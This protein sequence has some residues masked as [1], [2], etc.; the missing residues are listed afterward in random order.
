MAVAG[1]RERTSWKVAEEG[2]APAFVLEVVTEESRGRDFD[3]KPDIYEA[4]KVREYAA[5]APRR[6]D[7][8]PLLS[9]FQ[10]RDDGVFAPWPASADGALR[11]A[12]M[13]LDLVVVDERWL[14]LR[15]GNGVLAP[16]AEEEAAATERERARAESEASRADAAAREARAQAERADAAEVELSRLRALLENRGL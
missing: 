3:H 5:F 15:D 7:G 9:G 11:S 1:N 2:A 4:M 8:G 6:K 12:V 16:S 14:R 10:R 13:G